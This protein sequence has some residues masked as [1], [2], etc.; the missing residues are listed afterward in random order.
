MRQLSLATNHRGFGP[1]IH[2]GPWKLGKRSLTYKEVK[3]PTKTVV[4][5]TPHIVL[6]LLNLPWGRMWAP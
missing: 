6:V 2:L 1:F 3:S 4:E 5:P